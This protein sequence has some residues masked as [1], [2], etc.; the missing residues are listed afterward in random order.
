M[1]SFN[2]SDVEMPASGS[3]L[4]SEPTPDIS[5]SSSTRTGPGGDDLSI[6]EL[7]LSSR[8][9][10]HLGHRRPFSLLAPP[11]PTDESAIAEDDGEGGLDATMTQEDMEQARR[12]AA[13]T[14]EE[15][16]QHDLFVLKKLNTA[17]ETY[18]DALKE[19][20]SSTDR[21][22]TR[23]E[24]TNALL[25]KYV[26]ILSKSEKIT[27]IILDERWQGGEAVRTRRPVL[28]ASS[29]TRVCL[30]SHPHPF[31]RTRSSST[32]KRRSKLSGNSAQRR[33]AGSL[34]SA[35][36]SAQSKNSASARNARRVNGSSARRR[37]RQRRRAGAAVSEACVA[38]GRRCA[39]CVGPL[40]LHRQPRQGRVEGLPPPAGSLLL[41]AGPLP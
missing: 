23:L 18:K 33:S 19:T 7:S 17:F 5:S 28:R 32:E 25:D 36:A 24:H 4:L 8:P 1:D 15:K 13:K 11:Q 31:P 27:K 10:P 2:L 39:G 16:L 34:S 9:E 26:R 29:A 22:A 40:V 3:R 37:P 20:K 35:N 41:A 21:V 38:R 30:R 12:L 14:R 6:S